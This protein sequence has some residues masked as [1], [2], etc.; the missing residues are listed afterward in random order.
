MEGY[1]E[2]LQ[3][4]TL[5]KGIDPADLK[6][7]L[8][9]LGAQIKQYGKG[10]DIISQDSIVSALGIVLTGSV[11]IIKDDAFGN[12]TLV[13]KL[14]A[15]ELFAEAYSCVQEEHMPVG[16]MADSNCSILFIN[17]KKIV[18]T[19]TSACEFHSHLI[20]NMIFVLADKNIGLT[21]KIE[22]LSKRTTREKLLSFLSSQAQIQGAASFTIPYNRQDL[23]DFLC[24]DRSAMSNELSK[25]KA[26]GLIDFER[27]T[28]YLPN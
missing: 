7:L 9:C 11:Q 19:C 3:K 12:R 26:E 5:F 14:N 25:M 15:S 10:E 13:D 21:Q 22:H 23:A 16:V 28:F 1:L 27:N 8:K 6:A 24:V 2:A 20:Q 4:T 17:Y 18:T